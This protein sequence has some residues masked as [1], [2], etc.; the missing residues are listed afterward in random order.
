[1]S[2]YLDEVEAGGAGYP[3]P[4]VDATVKE[5]DRIWGVTSTPALVPEHTFA[6]AN[7]DQVD[8]VGE[9]FPL[10]TRVPHHLK[11]ITL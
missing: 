1:M 5:H 7:A 6:V 11:V 10:H 3:F 4:G 9:R 8:V 2:V